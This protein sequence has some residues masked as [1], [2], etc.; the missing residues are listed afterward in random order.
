MDGYVAWFDP[1]S[2]HIETSRLIYVRRSSPHYSRYVAEAE[3]MMQQETRI[4]R[5]R[6][7]VESGYS[8]DAAITMLAAIP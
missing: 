8:L 7:L 5:L 1:D 4:F 2:H 6:N 3:R